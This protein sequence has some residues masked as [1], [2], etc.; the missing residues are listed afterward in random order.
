MCRLFLD[1]TFIFID[2]CIWFIITAKHVYLPKDNG[3]Y[4][5]YI[6]WFCFKIILKFTWWFMK[7]NCVIDS[8]ITLSQNLF[9]LFTSINVTHLFLRIPLYNVHSLPRYV[10]DIYCK[11]V[12]LS[13]SVMYVET[14][15]YMWRL[16]L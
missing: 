14:L 11:H 8:C 9:I 16:Y 4:I 5:F 1:Q 6:R 3:S 2:W 15:L 12:V 10:I 7:V 13:I